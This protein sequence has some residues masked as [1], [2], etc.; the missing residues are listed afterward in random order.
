MATLAILTMINTERHR[1][2]QLCEAGKFPWTAASRH[3]RDSSKLAGLMEEVGEVAKELNEE[4]TS[5][6]WQ[7]NEGFRLRLLGELVQVA[8]VATAWAEAI[9][10]QLEE[11][12]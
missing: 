10:W 8:A 2:E 5:G 9:T 7:A 12:R 3:V 6:D 4:P 11:G 1:Q